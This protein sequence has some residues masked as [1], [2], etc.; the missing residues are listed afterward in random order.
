MTDMRPGARPALDGDKDRLAAIRLNAILSMCEDVVWETDETGR[1]TFLGP[2][3]IEATGWYGSELLG[4]PFRDVFR[5]QSWDL[6]AIAPDPSRP[7]PSGT[8]GAVRGRDGSMHYCRMMGRRCFDPESTRQTGLIGLADFRDQ[9]ALRA[10]VARRLGHTLMHGVMPAAMMGPRGRLVF[11]NHRVLRCFGS[12][13]SLGQR[14]NGVLGAAAAEASDASSPRT[15]TEVA[16]AADESGNAVPMMAHV[17]AGPDAAAP[18]LILVIDDPLRTLAASLFRQKPAPEEPLR[19]FAESL[20]EGYR[21]LASDVLEA[22]RTNQGLDGAD[23]AAAP[24][25]PYAEASDGAVLPDLT[26]RQSQVLECLARGMT[27]KEVGRQLGITEATV[28][29]H[30]KL[31]VEALGVTN[32]TAAAARAMQLLEYRRAGPPSS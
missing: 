9:T 32:R 5:D 13:D 27:N 24:S 25:L 1:L 15:W 3:I 6:R 7:M 29:T 14:L 23:A 22:L 11:A 21:A 30:V 18:W 16:G 12:E 17:R 8:L 19:A 4:Q 10:R 2:S 26:P 20:A 31:L 28:K